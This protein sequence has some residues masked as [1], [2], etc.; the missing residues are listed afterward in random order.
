MKKLSLFKVLTVAAATVILTG[1]A[2]SENDG[3]GTFTD[4]R[5]GQVYKIVKIGNQIWMAQNF[6]Y[7]AEGSRCYGEGGIV[8]RTDKG[9]PF[10]DTLSEE[11]IR[12][13][14]EKYGRLYDWETAKK[15][16]P[17][18][19]RLPTDKEWKKLL[20]AAGGS[21]TAGEKLKS[22]WGW[23]YDNNKGKSGSGTDTYGFSA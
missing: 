12:E 15:A 8:G 7:N 17:Q 18:G 21:K 16:A 1:C 22:N 19:W 5:D 2:K 10:P 4:S 3:T 13:N 6:N 14:C 20:N 11:Q 9:M 23:N